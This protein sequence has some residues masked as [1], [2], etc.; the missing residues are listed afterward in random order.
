MLW[1]AC[2]ARRELRLSAVQSTQAKRAGSAVP[3]SDQGVKAAVT[4]TPPLISAANH[5]PERPGGWMDRRPSPSASSQLVRPGR[6]APGREAAFLYGL[7]Q[8][9]RSST[10]Y[11]VGGRWRRP[12]GDRWSATEPCERVLNVWAT[13]ALIRVVILAAPRVGCSIDGVRTWRAGP[14]HSGGSVF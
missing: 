8:W 2:A 13:R 9:E 4:L 6:G 7:R 12:D 3:I 14:P 11:Y 1:D 5:L 10:T